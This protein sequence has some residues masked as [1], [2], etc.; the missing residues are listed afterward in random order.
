[1]QHLI[2][3]CSTLVAAV[4]ARLNGIA[5]RGNTFID[6]VTHEPVLLRGT[7]HSSG[8]YACVK[9]DGKVFEMPITATSIA[10]IQSWG[11]NALRI[12]LNEDCW[13]AINGASPAGTAYRNQVVQLVNLLT[14][15]GIASVIDLHWAKAGTSKATGQVAMPD[16]D[17]SP[18]F[19]H[20][21]A[22]TFRNNSLVLFELYNEPFPD[23]SKVSSKS[24]NC[25]M[26]GSCAG[27][28][29]L[30]PGTPAGMDS[31]IAAVRNTSG[32]NATNVILVAGLTWTNDL[33]GW[34]DHVPSDPL[35]NMGAVWH[36]YD[37]NACNHESCWESTIVPVAKA[38]PILVTESGFSTQYTS[39][40]WPW[41]ETHRVSYMAW[42]WNT[43]GGNE[44]LVEDYATGVPTKT[45]GKAWKKQLANAS[46]P[47]PP[48]SPSPGPSPPP[49]APGPSPSPPPTTPPPSKTCPACAGKECGCTWAQKKG[50]CEGPG[51]GSCCFKCCCNKKTSPA[52][53]TSSVDSFKKNKN[54]SSCVGRCW[55]YNRTAPCHCNGGCAKYGDCCADFSA[56][57][58]QPPPGPGPGPSPHPTPLPPSY[59]PRGG[60][61]QLHLSLTH[62]PSALVVSFA[63]SLSWS[64]PGPLCHFS[65]KEDPFQFPSVGDMNYTYGSTANT[66][67]L[68]RARLEGLTPSTAYTYTCGDSDPRSIMSPPKSTISSMPNAIAIVADLGANCDRPDGGCGNRTVVALNNAAQEGS[69]DMILH[70]GD[71]AYT[72]G[73]QPVWDRY[74]RELEDAASRVPYQVAVGNHESHDNFT[75]YRSRFCM[76]AFN[77]SFSD[78]GVPQGPSGQAVNNLFHAFSFGAVDFVAVSTERATS[79]GD[80]IEAQ[81][82]AVDAALSAAAARRA[83]GESAWLIVT[84]HRPLYC[85]TDDYYDCKIAGPTKLRP[86]LEP[87]LLKH[88]VDVYV[89]GHLHNFE[90]SYPLSVNG[91]VLR[92]DYTF[93][94][95]GEK[96]VVHIVAGMAGDD[97]GLTNSWIMP[98]PAWSAKRDATLGWA[99]F[100]AMNATHARFTYIS[101]IDGETVDVIDLVKPLGL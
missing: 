45:W 97:E 89:A 49:P 43:W 36:S 82:L 30:P 44:G 67:R 53:A 23:A 66:T 32:A 37:S 59:P 62:D 71:I 73:V 11:N 27:V 87:L 40:L 31:L 3:A 94:G 77:A 101:S 33:D 68:Y 25:L 21:V 16:M 86:A 93:D 78:S 54:S 13:L 47:T 74:L 90:R 9:N 38:V 10:A 46:A 83:R 28:G 19:W 2:L 14:A 18:A 63:T 79:F 81:W 95:A 29:D 39:K 12:P 65:V 1:M 22:A 42:T 61:E 92:E 15:A 48:P 72:S 76:E 4:V 50:A 7:S 69:I 100:D 85:S 6:T 35:K 52:I 26:L 20:S 24:W 70:G 91:T 88:G 99:R 84:G 75:G 5:I 57:C 64:R 98:T 96:G 80:D 60:V 55:V 51:D 58:H 8:E 56:V 17:H 34:L 41:L